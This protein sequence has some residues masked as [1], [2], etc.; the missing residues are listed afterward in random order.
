MTR[1]FAFVFTADDD[2]CIIFSRAVC[3]YGIPELFTLGIR[4]TSYD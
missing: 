2:N 4:Y 3:C 1:P